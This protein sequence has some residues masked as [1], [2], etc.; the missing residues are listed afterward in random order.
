MFSRSADIAAIKW[1]AFR[2]REVTYHLSHLHPRTLAYTQEAKNNKPACAYTVD[3]IF[4]MHCFT[5]G[6]DVDECPDPYMCYSDNR[7]TRVFDFERHKLSHHLPAIVESLAKRKC[8]H[9]GRTNFL[10]FEQFTGAGAKLEYEIYFNALRGERKGRLTL[11]VKSAYIRD[12]DHF[13]SRPQ[14]KP[15]AFPIILFNVL[16][17]IQIKVPK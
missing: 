4:S 8:Y 15:I 3:V 10:T 14:C 9:T 7:E 1:H 11:H 2:H 5:R 16:N 6:F 12:E 17:N 13:G